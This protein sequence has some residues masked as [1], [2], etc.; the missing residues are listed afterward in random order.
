[1]KLINILKN[2]MR[3]LKIFQWSIFLHLEMVLVINVQKKI[4]NLNQKDTT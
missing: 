3:I 4:I 1:M 2:L